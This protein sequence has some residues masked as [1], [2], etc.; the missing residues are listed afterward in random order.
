MLNVFELFEL[1]LKNLNFKAGGFLRPLINSD[2]M[3]FVNV[4]KLYTFSVILGS[5][6]VTSIGY[7]PTQYRVHGKLISIYALERIYIDFRGGD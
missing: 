5:S 1:F 3:Y 2:E 6:F 7:L 4:T